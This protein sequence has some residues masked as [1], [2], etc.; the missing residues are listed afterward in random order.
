[1]MRNFLQNWYYKKHA[2]AVT[3]IYLGVSIIGNA[4]LGKKVP[5][6]E[7]SL[8]PV[9]ICKQM[10]KKQWLFNGLAIGCYSLDMSL[11]YIILNHFKKQ[12]K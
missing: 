4:V 2:T 6:D 11:S 9:N 8:C 12:Y 3:G 5:E 7:K 1:L 10:T